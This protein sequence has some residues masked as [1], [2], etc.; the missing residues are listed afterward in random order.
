MSPLIRDET[1]MSYVIYP[2]VTA[3]IAVDTGRL[4]YLRNYGTRLWA[5]CPFFLITGGAE[6]LLVDTS[7]SADVM[8]RLRLEPVEPVADFRVALEGAGFALEDIRTV[9]H[10]HLMYDH[11][12]N[13]RL[14]PKAKFIVQKKELDFALDPH[15]MFAGAYQRNLFEGLPFEVVEGD[16]ELMPGIRLLVTFFVSNENL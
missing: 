2:I 5:P 4:T 9:I 6:P 7:G 3:R 1:E 14:L 11:C 15:P 16:Q 13:S 10:T 8:S 12:A